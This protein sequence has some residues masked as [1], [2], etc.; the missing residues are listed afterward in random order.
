[1]ETDI[2]YN[3]A[4]SQNATGMTI[5]GITSIA[6]KGHDYLDVRWADDV[7]TVGAQVRD[8]KKANYVYTHRVY[9]E[10]PFATVMGF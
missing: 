1:V 7:E 3:F 6:K 10:A 9:D 2:A 4:A 8:I 5:G